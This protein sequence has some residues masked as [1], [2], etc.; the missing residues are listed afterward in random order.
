M[1]SRGNDILGDAAE[2]PS[3]AV[4]PLNP[5]NMM[6]GWRRFE[7]V[8]SNLGQA[9]WACTLD[10]GENGTLPGG[11]MPGRGGR[12]HLIVPTNPGCWGSYGRTRFGL[13]RSGPMP[14]SPGSSACAARD[15][16]PRRRAK[17][18]ATYGMGSSRPAISVANS[19]RSAAAAGAIHLGVMASTLLSNASSPLSASPV[20]PRD[21]A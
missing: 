7:T 18:L 15:A 10:G 3:I 5:L 20:R 9:G 13:E 2:D 1:D 11:Y 16:I 19:F 17:R 6:L 12:Y 21:T 4:I 14:A 8:T